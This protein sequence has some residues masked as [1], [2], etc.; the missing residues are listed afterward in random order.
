MTAP[1]E[2]LPTPEKQPSPPATMEF[3]GLIS[4]A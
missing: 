2:P 1:T 3:L 4:L